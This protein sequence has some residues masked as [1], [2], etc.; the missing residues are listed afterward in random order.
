M[1]NNLNSWGVWKPYFILTP[2][3]M[4][5]DSE[6]TEGL[7]NEGQIITKDYQDI[8]IQRQTPFSK[9]PQAMLVKCPEGYMRFLTTSPLV[10][11]FFAKPTNKGAFPSNNLELDS[12]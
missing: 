8:M 9:E 1:K 3:Q 11:L 2:E 7:I 5:N 6:P 12:E 10:P 4:V